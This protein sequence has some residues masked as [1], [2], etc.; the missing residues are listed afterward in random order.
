[1]NARLVRT[2]PAY[3]P[4]PAFERTD[5]HV[6]AVEALAFVPGTTDVITIGRFGI[7]RLVLERDEPI[8]SVPVSGRWH[9]AI[10]LSPDGERLLTIGDDDRLVERDAYTGRER[11]CWAERLHHTR[12]LEF[13]ADGSALLW[14]GSSVPGNPSGYSR[15]AADLYDTSTMALRWRWHGEDWQSTSGA[16]FTTRGIS[17]AQGTRSVVRLDPATGAPLKQ[18]RYVARTLAASRDGRLT[19]ADGTVRRDGQLVGTLALDDELERCVIEPAGRFA[20]LAASW[21]PRVDI[22]AFD[23]VRITMTLTFPD[24]DLDRVTGI[25][26]SERGLVAIGTNGGHTFVYELT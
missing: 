1:M 10:A 7:Q 8:W 11:W 9:A 22:A 17:V 24:D 26:C 16:V 25:A 14:G 21:R 13:S 15:S 19:I 20:V 2:L 6:D 3:A 12:T 5:A 18:L 23:P 4:R